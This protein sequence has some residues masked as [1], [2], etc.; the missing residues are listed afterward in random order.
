MTQQILGLKY[1]ARALLK[2]GPFTSPGIILL[3]FV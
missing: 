2:L 3:A 1:R